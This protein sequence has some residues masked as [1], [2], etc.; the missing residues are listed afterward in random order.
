MTPQ[1]PQAGA[2]LFGT[3]SANRDQRL[4]DIFQYVVDQLKPESI[5][6][7]GWLAFLFEPDQA[8]LGKDLRRKH[9]WRDPDSAKKL[10][11]NWTHS[12]QTASGRTLVIN[13]AK[14]YVVSE[15]RKEARHV[16]KSG[17]LRS[18]TETQKIGP[19]YLEQ[20]RI[21]EIREELQNRCSTSVHILLSIAGVDPLI[22][23]L[24]S[25][26]SAARNVSHKPPNLDQPTK[27]C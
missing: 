10:L 24:G 2:S 4:L 17:V 7:A 18:V 8:K 15:I 14:N 16:T 25:A 5:T 6:F 3:G 19:E 13:W 9:F 23:T 11:N 12:R 21:E 20:F 26:P 1:Q 27:A 22:V